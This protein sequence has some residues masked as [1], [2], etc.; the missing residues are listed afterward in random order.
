MEFLTKEYS[1][2]SKSGLCNISAKSAAPMDYGSVKGVVQIAHGMAEHSNRY[3]QF[4]M[5][6]CRNGYA[7]FIN[8]HLGHGKSVSSDEMLGY[9]GKTNGYM[10]LVDDCKQL[11]DIAKNEYKGLPFFFF[12]HSMGSFIAREYTAHYGKGLDGVIYCG[13]SGANPGAAAGITLA[14]MVIRKNGEMYR[15]NF[16]NSIAFGTYNKRTEKRTDFDWLTKDE[17]IVDKY[18]EDK[19]CGFLFTAAGYRDL[20]RLLKSISAKSWYKSV[21]TD[22]PILLMS[23]A[24]D[25]VGEYGKGVKQVF[26][27]L[28]ETK[29]KNVTLNLYENDRHEIHNETDKKT[30]MADLVSWLDGVVESIKPAEAPNTVAMAAEEINTLLDEAVQKSK[31]SFSE[32]VEN[33]ASMVEEM[34]QAANEQA[35]VDAENISVEEI[36]IEQTP[37]STSVTE[38]FTEKAPEKGENE[39]KE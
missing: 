24:E 35:K 32:A 5:E 29:H 17:K 26:R 11:T 3:A 9:F 4:I 18:I 23:G 10:N 12:G 6:L 14:N 19:Y 28:K 8:D 38:V 2:P 25:P 16:I 15:S 33:A 36:L 22:L 20:F 13:T 7:V 39:N 27:D 30:V 31:E 21:P 37:E 34:A 1:F